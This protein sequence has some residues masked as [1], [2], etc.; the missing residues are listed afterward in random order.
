MTSDIRRQLR[1]LVRE[2]A[3][4]CCEYCQSSEWLSGQICHIDHITPRSKGGTTSAENLCL[5]CAS[6]N[7]LKADF[8]NAVDPETG[9]TVSL[10]NPRQQ[11]W[12][13]HF[14][15]SQDGVQLIG[16]TAYGRATTLLL[17]LNR[18]LAI[19]ARTVWAS[20]NLHPPKK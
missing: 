18:P 17:K 8:V 7:G 6:C 13:E 10:F 15:W 4:Y 20:M 1:A 2:R 16:L 19:A 9:E 5:A 12:H 14:M 3:N 11:N